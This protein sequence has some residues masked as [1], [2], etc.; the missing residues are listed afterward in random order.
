ML[1]LLWRLY[2]AL[3]AHVA[4]SIAVTGFSVVCITLGLT[5]WFWDQWW[6]PPTFMLS[7]WFRPAL[8][9]IGLFGLFLLVLYLAKQ[10][11]LEPKMGKGDGRI[12]LTSFLNDARKSGW[13]IDGQTS[14]HLLDLTKAL[15][16]TALDGNLPFWGKLNGGW[17]ESTIRHQPLDRIPLEHWRDFE[18]D[19]TCWLSA[20][21]N[22]DVKTYAQKHKDWGKRESYS[23]LHID[24]PASVS[25][26]KA[27]PAPPPTPLR[28][29]TLAEAA[30]IAFGETRHTAVIGAVELIIKDPAKML[31]FMAAQLINDDGLA[32]FGTFPPSE[33][34]ARI[35]VDDVRTFQVND[36]ATELFDIFNEKRRYIN[37]SVRREAFRQ[38]LDALKSTKWSS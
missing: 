17:D 5:D 30:R 29:I 6:D 37:L 21:D 1:N 20:K 16:Q 26:L 31:G 18:I 19:G 28:D 9:F 33:L 14:L 22:F 23:D 4:E 2:F 10:S 25:W 15:R 11:S 34:M 36:D 27:H 12:P 13:D 8:L 35:P 32:V 7:A 3:M 24:G 38:R